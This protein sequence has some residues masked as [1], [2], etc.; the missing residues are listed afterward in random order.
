MSDDFLP[1]KMT[2]DVVCENDI[3][4]MIDDCGDVVIV[5]HLVNNDMMMMI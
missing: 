1:N 2:M 5:T 3:M 4:V